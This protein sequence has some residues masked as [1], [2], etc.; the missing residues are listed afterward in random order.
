[1]KKSRSTPEYSLTVS[2]ALEVLSLFTV[3]RNEL[4]LA[5]ITRETGLAKASVLR[6]LQALLKHGY[7]EQDA[8]SRQFRPGMELF[9]I[10]SIYRST[11][12]QTLAQPALNALADETGFSTYF[13][14][15]RETQM[16]IVASAESRGVLR[17]TAELGSTI[18]AHSTAAGQA[19][20]STFSDAEVIERMAGIDFPRSSRTAPSSLTQLLAR[21]R[22]VRS[23]GYAISWEM[24]TPG[25]GSVAAPALGKN[26]ELAG[27]FTLGFG[28]GQIIKSQCP[29]LGAKVVAAAQ[30]FS[31]SLQG[32]G[33]LHD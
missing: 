21:L 20:L 13:S 1:M 33:R 6:F 32:A 16:V 15:L 28:T 5:E 24:S 23:Q 12:L 27:V 29:K 17:Y 22:T 9:R 11:S 3:D 25:V 19:A 10:G 26:Q 8:L 18:P 2:R 31:L 14:V 30:H 4:S 7:V